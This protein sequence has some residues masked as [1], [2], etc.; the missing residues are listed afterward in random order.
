MMWPGADLSLPNFWQYVLW[1]SACSGRVSPH[2]GKMAAAA[3]PLQ[4]SLFY[5]SCR[6]PGVMVFGLSSVMLLSQIIHQGQEG[7][8]C[9]L[10]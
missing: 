4:P 9:F 10:V 7:A 1:F 5:H 3:L 2:C 6:S 8:M